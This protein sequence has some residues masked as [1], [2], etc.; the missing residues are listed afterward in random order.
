MKSNSWW[1]IYLD[2]HP[3]F[4]LCF[5][6]QN[7]QIKH[8]NNLCGIGPL[9]MSPMVGP[10]KSEGLF[11][12]GNF[13]VNFGWEFGCRKPPNETF[14]NLQNKTTKRNSF[15]LRKKG[16]GFLEDEKTP[17]KKCPKMVRQI[18][19]R[20]LTEASRPKH[21]PIFWTSALGSSR[22]TRV[23]R[24]GEGS[25]ESRFGVWRSVGKGEQLISFRWTS[26]SLWISLPAITLPGIPL[27]GSKSKRP[28]HISHRVGA[29]MYLKILEFFRLPQKV[30]A[31]L[32][33][34]G[35]W[36]YMAVF[37]SLV[38]KPN[39]CYFFRTVM[40]RWRFERP[41]PGKVGFIFF[42]FK[43]SFLRGIFRLNGTSKK[44][45]PNQPLRYTWTMLWWQEPREANKTFHLCWMFLFL[46][47][48]SGHIIILSNY[49]DYAFR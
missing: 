15:D 32:Q 27:P 28:F 42:A 40:K 25:W 12:L 1:V 14:F 48:C 29:E 26:W 2:S 46:D 22:Q 31:E 4:V 43:S 10:K 16:G 45:N 17:K 30:G 39:G 20:G 47:P 11:R 9:A 8:L 33:Q 21:L 41:M 37:V 5:V 38:W 18:L 23:L 35:L 36:P 19:Q 44:N 24:F 3:F 6:H 49:H 7:F 34:L 13:Q